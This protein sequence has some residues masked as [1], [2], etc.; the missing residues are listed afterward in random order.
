MRRSTLSAV[1]AA[2]VVILLGASAPAPAAPAST[3]IYLDRRYS[4][5]ERA[6]DLVARM[7]L[8]EKAAEM[9][10][11]QAAAIPRLGVAAYGWWNEAAHGVAREGTLDNANPPTMV[12]TT[13]YPVD[14]ALGSTWN[15]DLMYREATQISDEAREV[16]RDN[17]LDLNFYSPTVNL[18]RDPRWGRNDETFSEDPSLTAAMAAQFV[19]GM[20][21]QDRQGRPLPGSAGYLKTSTTLK[22]Y[23][24]NNSEFNRRTGTSNMDD[25]TLR[26]YYTAQFRDVIRASDPTS[27]MS[28]YN[29]VN[30]VPAAASVYLMDT[31]AR[32]TF[33]FRGFFTSDCDAVY[34]IQAG[35]HWQPP[36]APAPLDQIGRTAFANSAGEDLNCQRG[37][38]DTFNYGNTIPAAVAAGT[39]T[40]TGTYTENDVDVSLVRLFATRIRL[41]EFDAQTAVPWV[42]RARARVAAGTWT[43][44]DANAAVT[45]TPARLAL[46]RRA[47]DESIV[48]LNNARGLLPLRVPAAGPYRLAVVG[49]YANPATMF[50]GGYSS[51]QGTAGTAK[52]VNGYQGIKAAV[53]AI[54]PQ[55]VVDFLPGVTPALDAV[56]Q[57]SVDAA[58][59]YDAVV[60]Y[61]GTDATTAR[62]DHDRTTLALPGAQEDMIKAIAARNPHT[63]VYLETTGQVDV[64]GFQSG[65]GALL[66]SSYNGQRK[67]EALAD[68][69]LGRYNPSGRLPFTWYRDESQLPPIDDYGIRPDGS[70]PGRT[71]MYFT[72]TPSYPFGYGLSYSTVRYA[73]LSLSSRHLDANGVLRASVDVT[74]LSARPVDEV[75]QLYAGTP[76][77]PAAAQRPVKRLAGFTKVSLR[78]HETRRVGFTV[79]VPD[80]AFFDQD[81]GRYTVDTGRYTIQV[82]ASSVDIRQKADVHVSG[83]LRSVPSV[84]TAK[85]AAA[86]DAA[87]GI[88]QRVFFPPGTVV[89]PHLTVAMTD[90]QLWGYITRGQSTPL[91][92]GMTVRYRSNRPWVVSAGP[93]GVLRTAKPGVATVTATVQYAGTRVATQFVVDVR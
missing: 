23:A 25:R 6:A 64:G 90:D 32:Q 80:L 91:P 77:A 48:L 83:R 10:S 63:V 40:Q 13:S 65:A 56:D 1:A 81:T 87:A 45:E 76:D 50:L 58:A 75:V 12:N 85:P 46:A 31:L 67:G 11:S 62:E 38:H 74:N 16:V 92:P 2:V 5:E 79:N 36:G 69:L 59:G 93:D 82:G 37:F 35:H 15:P 52:E 43:N 54:D 24:A 68:V 71:Y 78:P 49:Y 66:W 19:N 42:A 57:P 18:A 22:H 4:P 47:G 51:Q 73:D 30:G 26:E 72:G 39:V 89:D 28:A 70:N 33:G 14:L 8:A 44:S 60:V 29:E 88:T 55:A 34:E 21:G 84:L 20:E 61:A 17:S 3:A 41:G 86:G 53:Q 7:T 27:M 9:N